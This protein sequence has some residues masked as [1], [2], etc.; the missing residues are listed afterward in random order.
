MTKTRKPDPS[1]RRTRHDP[2][3][4]EEAVSAAQGLTG[5]LDQQ[6]TI[7]AGLIGWPEDEVRPI[8]LKARSSTRA[9]AARVSI[10]PR[11]VVVERKA[12]R[13]FSPGPRRP[14]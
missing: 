13:A 5:D 10:G 11:A 3:T 8:V 9:P 2:P 1:N 14:E 12:P 6:V 7:A 4:V